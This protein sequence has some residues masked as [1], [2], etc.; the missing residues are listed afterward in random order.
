MKIISSPYSKEEFDSKFK[1]LQ[2]QIDNI[3]PNAAEGVAYGGARISLANNAYNIKTFGAI[4]TASTALQG[5]AIYNGIMFSLSHTGICNTYDIT[6]STP[7]AKGSFNLGSYA[8]TN[9][10]NCASFGLQKYEASDAFPLMYVA[11]CYAGYRTCLVE[12]V[13]ETSASLVQT[14]S[15]GTYAGEINAD[16]DVQWVAGDDGYLYMF[17]NT[18]SAYNAEG[19]KFV[20]ARFTMPSPKAGDVSIDLNDAHFLYYMEDYNETPAQVLQG[21]CVKNGLMFLPI[22]N[23]TQARKSELLVWDIGSRYMRLRIDLTPYMSG[24]VEDADVWDG[25]LYLRYLSGNILEAKF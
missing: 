12:R 10:A 3:S 16:S 24:E 15:I 18:K 22:G 25:T 2:K 14:I 21:C 17:G 5:M 23:N 4:P 20:V 1:D 7:I 9:H 6:G 13:T 8:S 19:N 11:R